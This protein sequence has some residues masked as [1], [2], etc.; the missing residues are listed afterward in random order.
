MRGKCKATRW[1]EG[2]IEREESIIRNYDKLFAKALEA[3]RSRDYRTAAELLSEV[4]GG[5]DRHPQAML[6]L[7][8]AYHSL[9]EL[10]RALHV[11][12][13]YLRTVAESIPGRFFLARTC[14][15]LGQNGRAAALLAEVTAAQ[16][17]FAPAESLLGLALLRLHR[18][19][20]ALEHF[21]RAVKLAPDNE[22]IANGYLGALVVKGIRACRR[23][24]PGE[25]EPIFRF[26]LER[27]PDNLLA[28]VYLGSIYREGG[29]PQL[30]LQHYERACA[31]APDDPVLPMLAALAALRAGRP[32]M[33]GL[34][35]LSDVI[36]DDAA[37][38]RAVAE[39]P[40]AL[41]R[42]AALGFF[43]KR[44]FRE[45][46][47]SGKLA[48]RGD[49]HDAEMHSL[50][51][52]SYLSLGQ[53]ERARNHFERALQYGAARLETSYG[54]ALA[55][56]DL[57]EHDE[58]L[59]V[60]NRIEHLS[61]GDRT[62]R[63]FLALARSATEK[64]GDGLV[65][66]LRQAIRES[67]P[68]ANLM[69]ALGRAYLDTGRE[70]LAVGWL[71]RTLKLDPGHG[72]A[73]EL[74]LEAREALDQ[75]EEL[76]ATYRLYLD[77]FPD[78]NRVR[79]RFVEHLSARRL[80]DEAA[81]ELLILLPRRRNSRPL[82]QLLANCCLMGGRYRDAAV[83]YRELLRE[84]PRSLALLRALVRCLDRMRSHRAAISLLEKAD[85][86]FKGH[87][88]VLLPL[89]VQYIKARDYE[90]AQATLRR[91]LASSPR[92][93]RVHHNLARA[94]EKA[95]Q[96]VF[97]QRFFENARRFRQ[98]AQG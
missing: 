49:Y 19:T 79:R 88:E 62:G 48:L 65:G 45:A 7:G 24:R 47:R 73:L 63:Y 16:P 93:W 55:L 84:E 89:G 92:D 95:G 3:G 4:A 60:A 97:A 8:R 54:L 22:R 78:D 53:A 77:R 30:A 31:L 44:R 66:D 90:R 23:G 56:W 5:S 81:Q 67:G 12:E 98:A 17:G 29:Q 25:A 41:P 72:E 71:E 94:Y 10:P 64:A 70:D 74:L 15:A 80:W 50:V 1:S 2:Y 6:Y 91:L 69:T 26:V 37:V 32:E 35:R 13:S 33:A 51:A 52:S 61:P 40:D 34:E 85:P 75:D 82:R 14:L 83:L 39:N 58:L 27:R 43:R 87:A 28:H 59:R 96:P 57:G 38:G 42:V 36:G 11:L 76:Q 46:L 20:A 86:Y 21:E 68:D 18:T 9:G